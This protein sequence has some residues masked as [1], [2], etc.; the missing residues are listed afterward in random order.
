MARTIFTRSPTPMLDAAR[1]LLSEGVN[2]A[3][4]LVMRHAGAD[5]DA[6]RSTVGVAAKLAAHDDTH[7]KPVFRDYQPYDGGRRTLTSPSMRET[8]AAGA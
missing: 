5:H 6:L 2:P 8:E 3:T 1:V 4:H 7:G